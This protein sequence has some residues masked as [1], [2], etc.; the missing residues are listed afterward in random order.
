LFD[1]LYY[2]M[3]KFFVQNL[4]KKVQETLWTC[5]RLTINLSSRYFTTR[6][7][8]VDSVKCRK[9]RFSISSLSQEVVRC[10][11][12]SVFF[13][14]TQ[15]LLASMGDSVSNL[16]VWKKASSLLCLA[17]VLA[18]RTP[19]DSSRS[20]QH[21]SRSTI[22]GTHD[23]PVVWLYGVMMAEI[24]NIQECNKFSRM[25]LITC[26]TFT[27]E[28]PIKIQC[29]NLSAIRK[30]K[31]KFKTLKAIYRFIIYQRFIS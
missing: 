17:G 8:C 7:P 30:M 4:S 27:I 1:F 16:G 21:A 19:A 11:E 2:G 3:T 14:D 29:G 28:L 26:E 15:I 20:G 9:Q 22:P 23:S 10:W 5:F 13:P 31:F 24:N 25:L 6:K 18:A 12:V